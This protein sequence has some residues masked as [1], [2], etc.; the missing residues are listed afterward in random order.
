MSKPTRAQWCAIAIVPIQM[1]IEQEGRA[2][3]SSIE[4]CKRLCATIDAHYPGYEAAIYA[5]NEAFAL[6]SN[7][8]AEPSDADRVTA[9]L[10]TALAKAKGE[11]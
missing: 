7:P 9:I 6:L 3:K 2:G 1:K 8:D 4:T 11:A 10:Q 5:C